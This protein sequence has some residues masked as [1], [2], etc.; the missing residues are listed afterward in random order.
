M[1]IRHKI[2]LQFT[3]VVAIILLFFSGIVYLRA[4]NQRSKNFFDRL[5]GRAN[6]TA[7]LLVDVHEFTPRLLKLLDKNSSLRLPNEEVYVYSLQNVLLYSNLD[8][9]STYIDHTFL[10]NIKKEEKVFVRDENREILGILFTGKYGRFVVVASA[11]DLVGYSQEQNL[12]NTLG[13]GLLSG[14][15]ITII[16]SIFFAG[17]ALKPIQFINLEISRITA[18]N[19]KKRLN[20]GNKKDEIAELAV[21]FNRMLNRLEMAFQQQK[22]FVSQA[23]HELRTPLAALKTEIQVGLEENHSIE[24]YK[25]TLKNTLNDTERLIQ[26]SNS[27]L[28]LARTIEDRD[29]FHFETLRMEDILLNVQ[30]AI[31]TSY[32]H[33]RVVFDFEKIPDDDNLT[34]INGNLLLLENLFGNIIENACKYS[35]NQ[36]ANILLSF[37]KIHC[38]VK[39]KD[40]GI[41]IPENEIAFIFNPFFRASNSVEKEGFGIGLSISKRIAELH[42]AIIEVKSKYKKGSEFIIKIIH[43]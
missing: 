2:S 30:K 17:Q 5:Q 33:Y 11:N 9:K 22:Q 23:S 37:D 32:P 40:K 7:R 27:L 41:G 6:T 18:N 31:Q 1:Q 36:Q 34:L 12:V 43:Q 19:L 26:L 38:I 20:E 4:E 28:Q 42:N 24:E 8:K 35:S 15:L 16:L 10:D 13:I 39:I 21:N 3:C 14:I 25:I 29:K